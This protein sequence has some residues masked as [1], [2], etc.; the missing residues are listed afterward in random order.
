M[1]ESSAA[2]SET[3]A[4]RIDKLYEFEREPVSQDKL[5]GGRRFAALFA[6]EH[7]A[8]TEFV[9]GALF[10][11]WGASARDIVYGL[12]LGNLV[13]LALAFLA[14]EL[15]RRLVRDHAQP[16]QGRPMATEQFP[17]RILGVRPDAEGADDCVAHG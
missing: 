1:S 2:K 9:I 13:P 15:L 7:V 3:L 5:H 14:P 8:A 17:E 6:G 11:Q 4:K 16:V 12:I 10:V